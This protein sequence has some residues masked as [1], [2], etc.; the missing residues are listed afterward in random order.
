MQE[1]GSSDREKRAV[2]ITQ[3]ES[4]RCVIIFAN[5]QRECQDRHRVPV[6]LSPFQSLLPL[7]RFPSRSPTNETS[8]GCCETMRYKKYNV[9]WE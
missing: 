8:K 2:S 7:F 5:G 4:M 1:S 3:Q 6:S 9:P